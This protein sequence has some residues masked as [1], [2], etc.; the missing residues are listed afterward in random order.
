[1]RIKVQHA[2]CAGSPPGD[3]D[4]LL[5]LVLVL[6][7]DAVGGVVAAVVFD[8]LQVELVPYQLGLWLTGLVWCSSR[9]LEREVA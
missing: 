1:M 2:V 5:T 3:V 9:S 7:V 8:L 6:E 4:V